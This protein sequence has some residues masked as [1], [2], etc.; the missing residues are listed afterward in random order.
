MDA[1]MPGR[2]SVEAAQ[3][4]RRRAL[5]VFVTTYDNYAVAAFRPGALDYLVK[6]VEIERL[7]DTVA[8]LQERLNSCEPTNHQRELLKQLAEQLDPEF[9]AQLHR[10]VVVN[11]KPSDMG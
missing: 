9:V 2:S 11:Q 4:I 8:R 3:M 1:H 6:P 10:S 5:L 7:T